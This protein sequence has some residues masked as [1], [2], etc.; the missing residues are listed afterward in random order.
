MKI[1]LFIFL[2]GSCLVKGQSNYCSISRQHTMCQFQGVGPAC[3]QPKDRGL[4]A[5]EK[6]EVLDY[7]NRLRSRV[8]IGSTGQPP[9][10]DMQELQWDEELASVAQR[11][12]DQCKFSHDCPDCRRVSRFKVGQN[13]YQSFNTREGVK[14][15]RKAIDSWY[16]EIDIFP[17]SSV[18]RYSFSHKT[19]HYSQMMWAQTSRVGCGVIQYRKGRFNARL[20]ACNYGET[21]NILRR[22]V[23]K[24]GR[25]CSSCPCATTCSNDYPGLCAPTN[26]SNHACC[27]NFL[28]MLN[29]PMNIMTNEITDMTME[30]ASEVGDAVMDTFHTTGGIAMNTAHGALNTAQGVGNIAMDTVQGVGN[31]AINTVDEVN[32]FVNSGFRPVTNFVNSGF[33]FFSPRFLNNNFF[34]GKK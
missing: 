12:A 27:D 30:T 32:K 4:S 1:C 14:D 23:Y 21:G 34:H 13:L 20:Y 8:A 24:I 29:R 6:K 3:G 7:H 18:S 19:G 15:W 33:N 25:A 22:P 10:S 31:V 28:C 11:H 9:A 16:N 17:V 26:S 2:A 5:A